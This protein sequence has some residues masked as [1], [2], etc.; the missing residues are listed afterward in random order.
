MNYEQLRDKFHEHAVELGAKK[1]ASARFRA[2]AYARVAS[3][4]ESEMKLGEKVTEAGIQSLDMSDYMK[5]KAVWFMNNPES[6][7]KPKKTTKTAAKKPTAKKHSIKPATKKAAIKTTKTVKNSPRNS[8]KSQPKLIK[9]LS[10]FMGLGPEK[11]KALIDAGVTHVNQLHMKKYKELLPEETKVFMDLKPLQQIPREHIKL[12]E[13]YLMKAA[14]DELSLTI[15]GSYRREKS[16]SSDIDLMVVSD[17]ENAIEVLLERL[18]DILNGK[19]YPYSKGKDKMSLI[20]DMSELLGVPGK[21]YKIDAFRTTTE[22]Q[23]P[24]LLYSTGSKEFNVNMRGKAKKLGYLLNQKGLFKAGEKVENL[25]SEED[26][27]AILD[28]PYLEPKK[29]I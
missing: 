17:L 26:Y 20:V 9:E 21:V 4:I 3:R 8:P 19:V 11:A 13:P 28:M 18:R 15:T 24:M 23:I 5:A 27:F 2:N 10:E 6:S 14:D 25:N 1:D 12:L 29:R 7:G 22:D 16:H